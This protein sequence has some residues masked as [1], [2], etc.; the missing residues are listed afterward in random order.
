MVHRDTL[1]ANAKPI[2][3]IWSFKRKRKPD[4]ELLKHKARLCAH[5]GM[6]QWGDS[7]WETYS[8]VVNMLSVRLMLA[9]AKIHKL[10][11]KAIDFVLAFPQAK[12]EEDIWMQLPIGFQV[13]GQTEDDSDRH[14]LLKLE[15]N[16]YGLKQASFNWYEKLKAALEDR[17]LVPS[18]ID[19]CLYVGNRMIVLTYVDD[20]IIVGPSMKDIDAFVKSMK[21]GPENFILTDEGD[22]DKFLGIEITHLDEKRFKISQPYLIDRIISLLNIDTN[23]YGMETNSKSTPVGKPLL[24]KDLEGKPRKESWNYRTAVGML[25]YLQ[26]NTRPEMSMAVHQTA[27]FCNN[28]MLSHEKAI[29]RL[30]RYLYHTK[31]E[32]IVYNPDI[33]KGLECYVDADFAGGWTQADASDA[34]NVMSRTGMVIMYANCPIYWR[35]SLQTE[36]AL[37]TAEAE[38]I[39]LSSALREV[40][41]L[42]TMM[43]EIN[44]V[45]PLHFDKPDFVCTVHEDN[46][47]CIKMAT[48]TKFSPRT[49]HIALKYHHFK[50]HVKSGR[51]AIKYKPTDEQLADLLTNHFQTK[52]SSPCGICFVAGVT[53]QYIPNNRYVRF[54]SRARYFATRECENTRDSI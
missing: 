15:A 39:A 42:M 6:Q 29:K 4:G 8:P 36:I 9:L 46:Q 49:K 32:G 26:G 25:T 43:E 48:G 53:K 30:G 35:S 38:Y 18:D 14:Y 45:I 1:P 37:S 24:H 21:D 31:N 33:S 50:S 20:C 5:G 19:P 40:L 23:T 41:P 13:A 47:S 22:I 44:K 11:S 3:A 52:H 51:V 27:R 54:V 16:L 17:E 34:D 7:Y 10:E 28:P 2:K 12:L